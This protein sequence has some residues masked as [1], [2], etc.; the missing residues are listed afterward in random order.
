MKRWVEIWG[1]RYEV[2]TDRPSDSV[3]RATGTY[4]HETH[5]TEAE[6]EGAAIWAD[7]AKDKGH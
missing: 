2:E 6:T 1:R 4:M 3:W 7:W 5:Q